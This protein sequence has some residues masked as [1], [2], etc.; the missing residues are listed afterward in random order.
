M[1]KMILTISM[2]ISLG[3]SA[4]AQYS[5]GRDIY[6]I[7]WSIDW[8][9]VGNSLDRDVIEMPGLPGGHGGGNDVN[10][11]LGSGLVILTALGAGYAIKKKQLKK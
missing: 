5:N 8:G 11:P 2:I 6:S 9:D 1:K 3:V 4:I 7:D 10:A